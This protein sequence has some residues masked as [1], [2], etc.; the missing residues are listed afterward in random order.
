MVYERQIATAARLIKEKGAECV[1]R[2]PGAP[3]GSPAAPVDGV[4]TD[5]PVS[6][7]FLTNKNREAF[8]GLLS[9]IA[10]TELPT[11]GRG[12][13]MAG[14]VPF[15]PSLSGRVSIGPGAFVEPALALVP[16]KGIELLAPNAVEAILYTLRFA[17]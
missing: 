9:M 12:G 4:P 5:Y 1:W 13:L 11:S 15:T 7:V 17:E 10:G 16:H 14:N 6:I 8:A 2:E 3:T